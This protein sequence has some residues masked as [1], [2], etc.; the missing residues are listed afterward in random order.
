MIISYP[1]AL[2]FPW[3]CLYSVRSGGTEL[4]T[5]V[6]GCQGRS[7]WRGLLRVAEEYL[8]LTPLPKVSLFQFS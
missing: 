6:S 5:T 3:A 8:S 2:R 4:G 1:S 7:L